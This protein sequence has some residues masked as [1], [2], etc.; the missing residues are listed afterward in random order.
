[1]TRR[2]DLGI[3]L[4]IWLAQNPDLRSFSCIIYLGG[5]KEQLSYT[6]ESKPIA[7]G[8]AHFFFFPGQFGTDFY[9]KFISTLRYF[10]RISYSRSIEFKFINCGVVRYAACPLMVCFPCLARISVVSFKGDFCIYILDRTVH[11]CNFL[12]LLQ[13]LGSPIRKALILRRSPRYFT[14]LSSGV[15]HG[16]LEARPCLV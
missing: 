8:G 11:L 16:L 14:F 13:S 7:E 3:L 2:L 4:E 6:L 5:Q 1:M 10:S 15:I 12:K 9:E